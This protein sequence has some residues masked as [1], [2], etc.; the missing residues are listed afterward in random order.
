MSLGAMAVGQCDGRADVASAVGGEPGGEGLVAE[1][2]GEIP[3][4]LFDLVHGLALMQGG[5]EPFQKLRDELSEQFLLENGQ[6]YCDAHG[7]ASCGVCCLSA[8]TLSAGGPLDYR[9]T[10]RKLLSAKR[11]GVSGRPRAP[12]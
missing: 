6:R 2:Q 9:G 7:G 12:N 4:T 8:A 3:T 1:L 5:L 10:C 11:L